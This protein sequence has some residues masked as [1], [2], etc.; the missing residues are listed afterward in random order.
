MLSTLDV[1]IIFEVVFCGVY[2][3]KMI[4]ANKANNKLIEYEC[5]I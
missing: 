1:V 3:S 5:T 2:R 4:E